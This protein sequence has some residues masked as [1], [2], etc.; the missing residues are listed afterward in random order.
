M[1]KIITK[2]F[3]IMLAFVFAMSGTVISA[4]AASYPSAFF[5]SDSD[6]DINDIIV[7]DEATVGDNVDIRMLWYAEFNHE[8]Y[9]MVIYDSNDNPVSTCS[10]TFTNSSYIKHITVHWD[11]SD[12]EPGLYTVVVTTKFY[13]FYEWHEAPS[14]S[15]LYVTLKA[16]KSNKTLKKTSLTALS[17][18]KASFKAT[19][20]KVSG[21]K[22]YQ[23]QYSTDKKFKKNVKK[24]TVKKNDTTAKTVKDLKSNKTYYV[25][26]RTYKESKSDG[27]TKKKYSSWSKV[28]T[29][30]TK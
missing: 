29:V 27:E 16:K 20:K 4:Q 24:V 8:G 5:C 9:D 22:G 17:P 3:A 13:S 18:L 6:F 14:T 26:I 12:L 30:K 10:D 28:K 7:S 1:K 15:K 23:L 21:V 19:W 2:I 11:T 25:R